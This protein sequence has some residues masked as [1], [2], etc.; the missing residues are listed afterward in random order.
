MRKSD[1]DASPR[2]PSP[3]EAPIPVI[4]DLCRAQGEA[5]AGPFESLG[6]LLR[7]TPVRRRA[8]ADG[9]SDEYQRAFIAAL[10]VTGSPRKAARAIGKHAFGAEQLRKARGGAS[11]AAAWDAAIDLCRE[12]ELAGLKSGLTDLAAEQE[13][14]R[15]QRRDLILPRDKRSSSS[16]SPPSRER[17]GPTAK[18]WEGR[19][20]PQ[21]SIDAKCRWNVGGG[22]GMGEGGEDLTQ[23]EQ[24]ALSE[25]LVGKYLLKLQQEREARLTGQV[26]AA[27]FLLR[28]I[29]YFEVMIDICQSDR[30]V[31]IWEWLSDL[32]RDGHHLIDIARTPF[33]RFLDEAR[34]VVWEHDPN[35]PERPEHPPECYLLDRYGY[36]L[37][38]LDL[39]NPGPGMTSA[40]RMAEL[41]EKYRKAAM[42]QAEWEA[43][44]AK[45][46]D[47]E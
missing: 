22:E 33:S 40:Q 21:G 42:E 2:L 46:K 44:S 13:Q 45:A 5:G 15:A 17:E 32:R 19:S 41:E 18:R 43:R 26:V 28:Q 39:L 8:R 7:F 36:S 20:R 16:P 31:E 6:D 34:R 30:G 4:C 27:D 14:D 12:R 24:D 10:A 9:W 1:L 3:D 25:S 23:A 29:T 35:E 11:F 38:P 37:E 47:G